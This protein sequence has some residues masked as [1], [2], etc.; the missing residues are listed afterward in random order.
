MKIEQ[1]LKQAILNKC[2]DIHIKENKT[3]SLRQST[4]LSNNS[5]HVSQSEMT[6]FFKR[7]LNPVKFNELLKLLNG[8]RLEEIDASFSFAGRRFRCNIYMSMDGA[9]MALRL[10]SDKIHSIDELHL[11]EGMHKISEFKSGLVLIV[12]TTGSG[13]STTL[14]AVVD[15]INHMRNV[16]ILTIEEPIE[17]IHTQ[18]KALITQREVG[19]HLK[20]FNQGTVA[21]MR[22][23]PDVILVGEL[24]DYETIQNAIT[25]AETGHLVL[26]TLHAKSVV[27]TVDRIIDVFPPEQQEQ[28]RMQFT[29]V[30]KAIAQ[31][32]L[33]KSNKGVV[34]VIEMLMFDEIT[35]QMIKKKQNSNSIRDRIRTMRNGSMHITDN[36]M[37]HMKN[38]RLDYSDIINILSD[39]DK[40]LIS[41]R[42]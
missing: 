19:S 30:I 36:I 8:E 21:A 10:L 20:S 4:V 9:A 27:E 26:A 35:Q 13:K 25:L 42:K 24:R 39:E 17:Y 18:D 3:V 29:S 31:Q 41:L 15:E 23:D 7:V 16:H 38:H 6:E 32:Q 12:G 14:A 11:P 2:S 1:I 40:N 37:W 34:P 28:I 33:V 22:E 5:I